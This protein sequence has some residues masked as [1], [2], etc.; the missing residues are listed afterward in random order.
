MKAVCNGPRTSDSARWYKWISFFR[1]AP[2]LIA[3]ALILS[4]TAAAPTAQASSPDEDEEIALVGHDLLR[5]K[6]TEFEADFQ[7]S[8]VSEIERSV[9][10]Q[11][12]WRF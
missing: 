9:Y 3:A 12:T 4:L 6:H 11:L 1:I 7:I 10:V 5:R 2:R 8:P